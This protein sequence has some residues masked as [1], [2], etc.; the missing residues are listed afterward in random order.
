MDALLVPVPG[1]KPGFWAE[2]DVKNIVVRLVIDNVVTFNA[3]ATN[4]GLRWVAPPVV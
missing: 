1:P 2:R 4:D 3:L